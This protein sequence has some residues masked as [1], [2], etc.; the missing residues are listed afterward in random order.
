MKHLCQIT[1][2]GADKNTSQ[3]VIHIA[4]PLTTMMWLVM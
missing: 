2:L 4:I 3:R 1:I